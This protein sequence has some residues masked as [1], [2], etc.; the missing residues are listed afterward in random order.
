METLVSPAFSGR[1]SRN[2]AILC[3][4]ALCLGARAGGELKG[5]ALL[6]G[7]GAHFC[8]LHIRAP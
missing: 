7:V 3:L 2:S 4:P 6:A 1:E 5:Q 8:E